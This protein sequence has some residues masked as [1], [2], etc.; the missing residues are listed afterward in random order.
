M[1][2]AAPGRLE[3]EGAAALVHMEEALKLLDRCEGATDVGAYLD[4]A[5]CRLRDALAVPRV[6]SEPSAPGVSRD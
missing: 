3:Q 2:D 1:D 4:L 5:I 6:G